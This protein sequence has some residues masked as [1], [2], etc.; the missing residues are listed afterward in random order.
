M[1]GEWLKMETST[2]DKPEVLAITV[3][4]GWDDPDLTVGK[5]FKLWRWFDQ[6]TTDGNAARVTLALLDRIVGAPGFAKAVASVGWL[7]VSDVGVELPNFE[8]HNGATAKSRAQTAKRVANHKSNAVGNA[9]ANASG[10]AGSVSGALPREEKRREEISSS[11][12]SEEEGAAQAPPPPPPASKKREQVT[13]SAYLALC[14]AGGKKPVPD[15]HSIRSWAHDAGI[16][17]EMLQVAWVVFR[18]R[19]TTDEKAKGK[20]YKDWPGVFAN[21]VKDRWQKLWFIAEDNTVQ[22]TST[23]LQRKQVLDAHLNRNQEAQHAGA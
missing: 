10:N 9:D 19:Y 2:P 7:R 11:L 3:E 8:R 13:L 17:D 20:R 23:G 18:E 16:T 12:R 5:L 6:H 14:K 4:M 22:W 1:A 21:A 15:D